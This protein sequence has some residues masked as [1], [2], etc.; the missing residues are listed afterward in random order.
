VTRLVA[1]IFVL[2]VVAGIAVFVGAQAPAA[3]N[4]A[5]F[6]AVFLCLVGAAAAGPAT[7][8]LEA[9]DRRWTPAARA[10][11][12]CLGLGAAAAVACG[13]SA[14]RF[15]GPLPAACLAGLFCGLYAFTWGA[16]AHACGGGIMRVAAAGLGLALLATFFHWDRFVL[17]RADDW[18]TSATLAFDLNPAAA[19][20]VTLGFDWIHS[21]GLYTGNQTAESLAGIEL[22]GIGHYGLR[23]GGLAALATA[24]GL[25]R[26][27]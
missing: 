23:L 3:G 27:P 1:I 6:A 16:I 25:W 21:K 14:Y 8:V 7:F 24:A 4:Q 13:V 11:L 26:K 18:K 12:S 2:L 20:S 17:P 22:F 10:A 19:A 5:A 15:E 9:N